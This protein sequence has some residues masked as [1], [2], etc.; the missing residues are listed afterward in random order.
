M[1]PL[2]HVTGYHR[3]PHWYPPDSC[4]CGQYQVLQC[5]RVFCVCCWSDCRP[6]L[7][8]DW[9]CS[10]QLTAALTLVSCSLTCS[11]AG[12]TAAVSAD[13]CHKCVREKN[14]YQNH[15]F[16]HCR[17]WSVNNTCSPD[18]AEQSI[19]TY[20]NFQFTLHSPTL[21]KR[22]KFHSLWFM[23]ENLARKRLKELTCNN[24][25]DILY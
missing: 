15:I 20:H 5:S 4:H 1:S 10:L 24:R 16:S 2:L 19:I 21:L 25:Q 7:T 11:W 17:A 12:E 3:V 14:Q 9:V 23:K 18:R 8:A 6:V 22:E 13:L